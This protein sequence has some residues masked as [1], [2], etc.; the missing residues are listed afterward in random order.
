VTAT[1]HGCAAG[2]AGIGVLGG[3]LVGETSGITRGRWRM[4]EL[5]FPVAGSW[6][7]A[8]QVADGITLITE[9][10]VD[11]LIRA[12]F[13]HVRGSEADLIV[14]TGTGIAPLGWVLGGLVDDAKPVIAVATHTHYDHAG[15]MHEFGERLVHPREQELLAGKGQFASLLAQD[16]PAAWRSLV[17]DGKH[18]L[19]EVLVDAVPFEGCDPRHYTL[20]PADATRLVVEGDQITLGSRVFEVM[21]TPGH[22]P[23]GICL[24]DRG[25]GVLFSGDTLYDSRLFD[26]LPGSDISSYLKTIARLRLLTGIRVVCPGHDACFDG[27]RL[28]ELCGEYLNRRGQ[29]AARATA[30]PG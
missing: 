9:P 23:G 13:Y 26:E 19:P 27:D 25:A 24:L 28:R 20:T 15:G 4:D 16:F 17:E 21:H 12:N 30:E 14:D 22:S 7:S 8:R 29:A 1:V 18:Q 11:P 6:F 10:H 3:S 5:G 2:S